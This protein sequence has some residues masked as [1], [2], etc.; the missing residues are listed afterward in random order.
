LG[1]FGLV[2]RSRVKGG[3]SW[4]LR[5]HRSYRSNHRSLRGFHR[6]HRSNHRSL[7]GQSG[8]NSSD[9]YGLRSGMRGVEEL[10]NEVVNFLLGMS[11]SID[12]EI[13]SSMRVV[14]EGSDAGMG[15]RE[16]SDLGDRIGKFGEVNR[17]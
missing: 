10:G 8:S 5:S 1:V 17:H 16:V 2:D 12:G 6:S 15:L 11:Q 13:A 9:T 14:N 3:S 7:R 4:R